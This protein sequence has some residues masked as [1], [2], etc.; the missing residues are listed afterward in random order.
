MCAFYRNLMECRF[1]KI[2][3]EK[4]VIICLKDHV[5]VVLSNPRLM[6]GHLLVIPNRHVLNLSELSDLERKELFDTS[7]DFQS[8]IATIM[9]SG[10]DIRQN[11]RPFMKEGTIKVD[12]VHMHILPRMLYDELYNNCE[13]Y[14]TAMYSE[15]LSEEKDNILKKLEPFL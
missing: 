11:F 6:P 4:T 2:N 12:H 8:K 15:L 3:P 10:C 9:K 14:E 5:K 7:I 13:Q 1:C